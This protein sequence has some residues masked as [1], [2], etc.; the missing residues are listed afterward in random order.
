MKRNRFIYVLRSKEIKRNALNHVYALKGGF[1]NDEVNPVWEVIIQEHATDRSLKQNALMWVIF[2]ALAN[3]TG[4]SKDEMHD[5][6]CF[7]FL[8]PRI[9]EVVDPLTGEAMH[10]EELARTSKLKVKEMADFIT[11]MLAYCGELGIDIDDGE[12]IGWKA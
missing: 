10:R 9:V 8:P 5:L 2:T 1:I 6:M 12:Y 3:H 4:Y 11:L 7:K